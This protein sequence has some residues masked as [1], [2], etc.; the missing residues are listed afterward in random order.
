[1]SYSTIEIYNKKHIIYYQ[2]KKIPLLFILTQH[3]VNIDYQCKQ[4][5][6][7]ACRI[8]LLKG[9]IYYINTIHPLASYNTGDIFPCCCIATGNI[10]IKI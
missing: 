6:C 5:Y 1:M 4:G 8:K 10:I 7:G 3:N 9:N 2:F